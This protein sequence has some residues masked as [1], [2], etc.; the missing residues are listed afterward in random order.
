M[1]QLIVRNLDEQLVRRLKVRAAQHGVSA[2][3]EHRRILAAALEEQENTGSAEITW[4]KENRLRRVLFEGPVIPE[5]YEKFFER[6]KEYARDIDF[7]DT[8]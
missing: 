8:N 7:G 3:E 2:E 6:S 4:E 5:E 1:A